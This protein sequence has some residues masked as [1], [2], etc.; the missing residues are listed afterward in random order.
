MLWIEEV[1][2][3]TLGDLFG[4]I[5]ESMSDFD[6]Y[7]S[8]ERDRENDKWLNTRPVCAYCGEH[9]T[10]ERALCLNDEWICEDCVKDNMKDIDY[11]GEY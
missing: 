11:Y 3:P 9:I 1:R 6:V 4:K 7:M 5:E 10:E 2:E 8:D